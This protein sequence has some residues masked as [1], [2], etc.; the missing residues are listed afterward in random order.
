M[1]FMA[2]VLEAS[3]AYSIIGAVDFIAIMPGQEGLETIRILRREFPAINIIAISDGGQ[4]GL[5]EFLSVA[6]LLGAQ[7]TL[8]KPF[9]TR[10]LLAAV[11]EVLHHNESY[12]ASHSGCAPRGRD[13]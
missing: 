13:A 8:R 12:T 2:N 11:R 6:R 5:Q 1:E 7:H 4:M 3:T 10:E 9:E